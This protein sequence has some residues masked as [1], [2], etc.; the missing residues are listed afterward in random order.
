MR[1]ARFLL[2]AFVLMGLTGNVWAQ[3]DITSQYIT[4]ATLSDGT[5]GWTV[6]NFNT[7]KQ[8]NNTVG[9]ASEAYAG[10]ENLTT[11]SYSMLQT[12][13]LPKGS[14]RLVNYSFFRQGLR[15]NSDASKSLAYLKAGGAQVAIR[16]LGS[17]SGIP[18]DGDNGGYANS[19]GDGANCFDAKMY[20]NTVEF[21]V[22]SDNSPVE[23]G[24]TGTFDVKQ[25]WC[26]V[27][28]FEL[29]D[30]NNAASVDSPTDV[31]YA[32]TNS[33]FEYRNTTGWVSNGIV[34]QD[35]DWAHKAGKGFAE[36]WQANAG[37]PNASISQTLNGLENGLYELSVYGQNINQTNGDAAST[38]M[39]L[40]ANDVRTEIGAYDQY[41][42]R[43]TVTDG[44]LTIGVTL[45]N[46]TGN[47]IAFD[48]FSLLFYGDP[49]AA[50]R[51]LRDNYVSEAEG[52][53]AGTD[54]NMLSDAQKSALQTA[55]NE[56]QNATSENLS[57]IVDALADAIQAARQ[58]IQTAKDNRVL[59]LA[60]LERFE[61]EYNLADGTDYSR[62]TMS[63]GAW[64][65]LLDKVNAVSMALD[66]VSL[67]SEYGARR[68]ALVSQMDATDASM[69]L[70]KSYKA[71]VEGSENLGI[72][73]GYGA[74]AD[75]NTDA[76]EQDAIAALNTAF[77]TY[78][79][80]Q[81]AD[82]D[83]SAFLGS[84]LDFKAEEGATLNNENS[85]NIHDVAGWEVT[86]ADADTWAVLQ[87]R[88]NDN[89]EKLYMRKNWGSGA[90]TLTVAKQKMLPVGKYRLTLSWNS[91]LENMTN[92]SKYAIGTSSYP[93]GKATNAAQAL[94]Y[95]FNVTDEARP[96][97]LV[98]GFQK[99][100]TGNTPAQ[101]V[102]DDVTLTCL[103]TAE[104][105]LARDYDPAALWFDAT[106]DKYAAAKGVEV[107]P[108]A[109]NQIIKAAAADQFSG[110]SKNVIVD[111]TCANFV[112]TDGA[113]LAIQEG[114]TA[115][116]ATYS[117]AM[118]NDWGTIILPFA[119]ASN[120]SVQFYALKASNAESMTFSQVAEVAASSPVAFKKMS[121]EAITLSAS[122]AAVVATTEQQVD[123]TTADNW[124][125]EGSYTI[126][127]V[128]DYAGIYYVASNKFWAADGKVSLNPFR[129]MFRNT[130][131]TQVKAFSI[132]VDV[133]TGIDRA[134]TEAVSDGIYD[135]SGRQVATPKKPG[136]YI[137]EGKKIVIK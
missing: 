45:D 86:Y 47:W 9:Y 21:E 62:L 118:S 29:F 11:S 69:R 4:N 85:N 106:D 1:T 131:S 132:F 76:A 51:S 129:A 5:T 55:V 32:V 28:M 39:F 37:L 59:M 14:Y 22:V 91:N 123:N 98:F 70:F 40:T 108:T 90:T 74:D 89:S 42:V 8:G 23:I 34:Y 135:L 61:D 107:M 128:E 104:D 112:I 94:T 63:E 101:L 33:G 133:A 6:S 81:D 58:L 67:A 41:K 124:R 122:D 2:A 36:K 105:L 115:T 127:S 71:M 25:S 16:T 3:K 114:F 44:T 110:L 7:P 80:E 125:A 43:T 88:Q 18:T 84:N 10:W 97:D 66:D 56:A 126:Q 53:L 15:Y 38:G 12:I 111:G 99:T 82:F 17:I 102:V 73:G 79:T 100:G 77:G 31:T 109:P 137:R 103:R 64:T 52:L 48:R 24:I 83:V 87:T 30:L 19:Q 57:A 49:D 130:G 92:L 46:C 96:F 27:G 78:A 134:S 116:S 54:A 136:L 13:T 50:L 120:E 113:P 119:L 117:R 35:N 68:D 72:A 93:I 95:D 121:G 75:M 65:S 26:I 60:A 20:R